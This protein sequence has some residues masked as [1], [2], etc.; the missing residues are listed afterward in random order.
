MNQNPI[1]PDSSAADSAASTPKNE[2]AQKYETNNP[3]ARW[4]LKNFFARFYD[5]LRAIHFTTIYEAGCG[6]GYVTEFI[7]R[8]YPDARISAM[9]FDEGKIAVAK[10]RVEGVDFSV[11][12][13]YETRQQENAFDLVV[14]TEVLE[15]LENPGAALQELVRISKRYIII[16]TPN[17]P[18]WRMTNMARLK[19]VGALGNTPGHINHWSKGALCA[20]AEKFCAV[21]RVKTPFPFTILL[22]EKH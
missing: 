17:E 9:D 13:I 7:K 3:I 4:I 6:N 16:S 1:T 10:S 5:L 22:L 19:Y 18:I 12:N 14:S 21:R 20:L 11:G 2:D 8:K 15:H